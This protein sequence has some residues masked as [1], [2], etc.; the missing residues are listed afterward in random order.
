MTYKRK[1]LPQIREIDIHKS[2]FP[3]KKF[4]VAPR[5]LVPSQTERVPALLKKAKAK[6]PNPNPIIIDINYHIINGHHRYD[7]ALELGV[8]KVPVLQV[9]TTVKELIR[10]FAKNKS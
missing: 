10:Y 3:Y 8:S 7:A 5:K 1:D 2:L 9:Q 4:K 6:F